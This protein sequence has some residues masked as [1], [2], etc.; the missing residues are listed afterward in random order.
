VF[1]GIW[2]DLAYAGRSLAKARAFAFVCVVSLGIGMAPVIAI[3]YFSRA[4]A[5]Q[6]IG[7][8]TDGLVEIFTTP[9]GPREA[10]DIWSYPDYVDLR[11]ADTG[12][13]LVGWTF[14]QSVFKKESLRAM[15]VSRNYFQT[16]GVT[17]VRGAG[18]SAPS[19]SAVI[20]GYRYWQNHL[21]SDP[22]IIG[23]TLTLDDVPHVV[24]GIAPERFDGHV[25][26]NGEVAVFLPLESHANFRTATTDRSREWVLIHGRLMP[27]VSVAQASAAVATVTSSLAKQYPSTNENKLGIAAPYDPFGNL[28]KSRVA[29]IQALALTLTGMVLLVVCLNI[30]GMVQVRSAMRERELSIRQAL[31]ATRRQLIQYLLSEAIVMAALGAILASVVLFNLLSLRSLLTDEPLPPQAQEILRFNLPTVGFAAG[32]CFLT[33][34]VFGLLPAVRFSRPVI[35]SALKDDAGV[36]GR[37]VGRV[38]RMIAALQVAIAVPLIVLSGISLDRVRSTATADL[39]FAAELLYAVPLKVDNAKIPNADFRVRRV[40]D[41]LAR[42][43]GVAG[44]SLAD[45]LPLAFRGDTVR[46]ALQPDANAAPRSIRVH[47]TRVDDDYL[48]TMGIPLL[49]GRGFAADDRAGADFVTIISKTLAEKLFPNGEAG[50]AIGRR[51]ILGN[52]EKTIH[53]VTVVGVSG[54]FP[55]AQMSSPREQLLLPLAQHSSRELFLIARSTP[56]ESPQKMIAAMANAERDFDPEN[57]GFGIAEDGTA[58]YPKVV[59]GAWLRKHSVDDFLMQSAVA[60]IAGSVILT[61]SALGIYGVVGLMVATRTRELAVRVALGASRR[62]VLGMVLFDVVKLVT[63]GVIVGLVLTAAFIR[64]NGENLGIP[65]SNVESLA[66]IVGAAIAVLVAVVASLAPARRAASVQP[67]VAMRSI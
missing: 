51:L 50:Q 32:L 58:L 7:V 37:R 46:T 13:A 4:L 19:E 65:L 17:L 27:G 12:T 16:L 18:F 64:L 26:M 61:L 43:D 34:L 59:T 62:R 29:V 60:G 45:G 35:L 66:Y 25:S 39:G 47:V 21:A 38:Q 11:D 30:S 57:R 56:G 6:P 14:G 23:K 5:I 67:M 55:T 8:K 24:T 31:G 22:D 15:F 3:P 53:T 33:S 42:T 1:K 20:L 10:T 44:A 41:D 9:A 49:G 40:R 28:V 2:R 52:D 48:S 54:D 63:P 36:G